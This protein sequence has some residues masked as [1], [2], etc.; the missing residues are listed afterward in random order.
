MADDVQG[1]SLEEPAEIVGPGQPAPE[2]E[3]QAE[4]ETPPEGTIEGTGGVKFVPL[5]AVIAER[6][7]RKEATKQ[8]AAKDAEIAAL[9]PRAEEFDRVKATVSQALPLIEK[10][11]NRPDL[12]AQ[13]DQPVRQQETPKSLSDAEAIEYAKDFDLYTPD[14]KPDVDRA[15]R[16]AAKHD[17]QADRRAQAVLAPLQEQN[18][19]QAAAAMRLKVGTIKDPSGQTVDPGILDEV[20]NVV[21]PEMSARPEV[22]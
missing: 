15:Q 10:M 13:L 6:T 12:M 8:L 9:K 21:P 17:A 4:D 3:V 22:A 16:I 14:G 20:W 5:G 1:L 2:A 7:Q 11:K 19:Q 18:A